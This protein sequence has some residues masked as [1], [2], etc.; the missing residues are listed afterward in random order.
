M[1]ESGFKFSVYH[2]LARNVYNIEH[3]IRSL[4][5]GSVITNLHSFVS[6]FCFFLLVGMV[7]NCL[8]T[9][10]M[11]FSHCGKVKIFVGVTGSLFL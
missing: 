6:Q 1:Q 11:F 2:K 7:D 10:S 8:I 9:Q 5:A 3:S 4:S